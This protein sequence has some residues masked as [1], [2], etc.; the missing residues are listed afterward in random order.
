MDFETACKLEFAS[1][2]EIGR[3]QEQCWRDHLAYCARSSSFYRRRFQQCGIS[4]ETLSLADLP[5]LPLTSKAEFAEHNDEFLAVPRAAV[6]DIVLSS[7]TTGSPTPVM[8]TEGDLERLAHNE[9]LSFQAC[10]VTPDDVAL[11][12]CTLDRCFVAGLAYFLG[13]RRLGAACVRNGHNTL[14]SHAEVIKRT[15]P[16]V[17]V[18]VPSFLR[19]L[20]LYLRES[21]VSPE[22]SGVRRLVC[23]GE[24]LRDQS[25]A[26]LKV[27]SDLEEIWH[28]RAFST[29]A[30][31]E[32]VTTFCECTA[33][34]GGHLHPELAAI[35]IVDAAGQLLPPGS[36]GEVVLTPFG[37]QGMP[38][39]RFRT[40]DIGFL[41]A[42]PCTCGRFTPRLGP[43]IGRKQQMMKVR[44]TTLYPQAV[45]SALD[46]IP[47]V[48]EY[49]LVVTSEDELS[50]S[51]TVHA[52]VRTPDCPAS[53]LQEKLKASLRVKPAVIVETE[54]AVRRQVYTP[55]S[56]KPVRFVD[57]RKKT[58]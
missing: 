41:I 5:S 48:S 36:V 10:G 38:L 33:Q 17:I 32:C 49:Y 19:R 43:I 30:S 15:G 12:T 31:S 52:A 14:E 34:Q 8:Y 27:G 44:G 58:C 55:A 39:L 2:G 20:G 37:I 26:F 18:G 11:L 29:Y 42:R 53:V 24:P 45:L 28:A 1:P 3:A 50:D 25:L 21:G 40:G 16:T 47:E 4:P 22:K 51:L 54:E 9:A 6:V 46:A 23:I 7:G 13:L 57:L 56:R 35:E